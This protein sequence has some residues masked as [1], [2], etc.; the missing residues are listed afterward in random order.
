MIARRSSGSSRADRGVEPTRSQNI[1]V[2]W[3]RSASGCTGESGASRRVAGKCRD[4]VEQQSAM[5]HRSYPDADQVLGRQPRQDLRVNII[6][7]ERRLVLRKPEA[8]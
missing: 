4:R 8:A 2:T 7:A 3:R 6:L 5:P 1:T